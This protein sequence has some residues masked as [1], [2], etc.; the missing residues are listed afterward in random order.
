MR[1]YF[2]ELENKVLE[3]YALKSSSSLGRIYPEQPDPFRTSFQRD[4]DRILHSKAFRRLKQKTQVFVASTGDHYRTRLT[5]S[6]EVSQISR[7]LARMLRLN[8][9]VIESIAL[10][11]DLGHTPFGHVGEHELDRLLK[12]VGGFEHNRQSRR[13]VEQLEH[14]YPDFP[15]LN[16]SL[17]ILDGLIKHSTPYDKVED[18]VTRN[19]FVLSLEAQVVNVADEIAYNNHDLDD[20][21]ASGLL[22]LPDLEKDVGL[23]HDASV[24]N[25]KKYTNISFSELHRL[26]ISTLIGMQ[27]VDVYRTTLAN[28]KKTGIRTLQDVRPGVVTFSPDMKE[29]NLV[30]RDYLF[31]HFYRHPDVMLMSR[32]GADIISQLF[33]IYNTDPHLLP[34]MSKFEESVP[35]QRKIGD[36]IASMTDNFAKSTLEALEV[37]L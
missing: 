15:G 8:E 20:G 31:S 13:V 16:L 26:N 18:Q 1:E 30:L 21:I 7:Q 19:R 14:R 22:S 9:D 11:H 29:K 17:E 23:W 28:I 34:K 2:E 35:I 27:V 4:R 10:S 25:K 6:L 32:K 12:D 37:R 5:H 3:T 24:L 36:Y 33:Q